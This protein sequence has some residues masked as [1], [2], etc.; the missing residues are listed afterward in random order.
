MDEFAARYAVIVAPSVLDEAPV[1][2]GNT[3]NLAFCAPWTAMHMPVVNVPGFKG[4]NGLPVG[5]SVVAGRNR[6]RYLLGVCREIGMVFEGEGGW[7]REV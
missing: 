5:L 1:G 7:R 3:G 6:D 2:Q 4:D